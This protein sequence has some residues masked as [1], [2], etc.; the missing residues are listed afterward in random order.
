MDE[1]FIACAIKQLPDDQ[2]V[3]AARVAIDYCPSNAPSADTTAAIVACS[4]I[5]MA[6]VE[7]MPVITPFSLA[8]ITSRY[9][10]A[11]GVKLTV[12]FPFDLT[13][14]DLKNKIVAYMNEWGKYANV[15]FV[16]TS[17][18]PQVRI[19]R[20]EMAYWSYLGTDILQ[21]PKN[22]PTMMLG[23]FTMQTRDSEFTRVVCHETGHTLGF[24]HEHSR[25]EIVALLDPQRTIDYFSRTQGW[26]AAQTRA[27]VLTPLSEASLRG[28]P[29]ADQDSIMSY[30]LPASITTNG[31]PIRGGSKIDELDA[32]WVAKL[33]PKPDAPVPPIPPVAGYDK[34]RVDLSMIV[35]GGFA[36]AVVSNVEKAT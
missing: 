35:G 33:Y 11:S 23:N 9:W 25:Q 7:A 14:N 12:G 22:Q 5:A 6:G 29:H 18:D 16:L 8:V 36:S 4:T 13:P 28:T 27:Q 15:S 1:E 21:I 30:Q 19:A 32:Q 2:Q 10:G 34:W 24:P 3:E 17:T 20:N 26:S 31:Q